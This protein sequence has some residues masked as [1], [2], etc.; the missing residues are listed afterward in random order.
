MKKIGFTLTMVCMMIL[1]LLVISCATAKL[2]AFDPSLPKSETALFIIPKHIYIV[3]INGEAAGWENGQVRIPAGKHTF[4]LTSE[5]NVMV[6][7]PANVLY[8]YTSNYKIVKQRLG[9]S[10]ISYTFKAGEKYIINSSMLNSGTFDSQKVY[11]SISEYEDTYPEELASY[12]I[13]VGIGNTWDEE[14]YGGAVIS[15]KLPDVPIFWGINFYSHFIGISGDYLFTKRFFPTVGLY[16]F[17]GV[18][19]GAGIQL[20]LTRDEESWDHSLEVSDTKFVTF[21]RFPIGLTF[22]TGGG[23]ESSGLEF[24]L[25]ITPTLGTPI[26]DFRFPFGSWS[27]DFCWRIYSQ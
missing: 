12:G 20:I 11:Y 22:L 27:I 9:Q 3:A 13:Q 10:T 24:S 5:E 26:P 25:Q 6:Y 17:I 18:G 14:L 8:G 2:P 7:E 19:L 21:A 16:G 1:S 15:L 4:T 23:N